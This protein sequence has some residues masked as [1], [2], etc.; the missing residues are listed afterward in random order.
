MEVFVDEDMMEVF[1]GEDMMEVDLE[2]EHMMEVDLEGGDPGQDAEPCQNYDGPWQ[3][4]PSCSITGISF[5]PLQEFSGTS[6]KVKLPL[7]F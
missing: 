5:Y 7:K 2:D 1:E 6:F 4:R 3:H